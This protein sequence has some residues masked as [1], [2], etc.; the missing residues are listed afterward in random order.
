MAW[1]R[2]CFWACGI[3]VSRRMFAIS[4][5]RHESSSECAAAPL[6]SGEETTCKPAG[7]SGMSVNPS[8]SLPVVVLA[9][10][11][12]LATFSAVLIPTSSFGDDTKRSP[13]TVPSSLSASGIN[14][15]SITTLVSGERF[16]FS[17]NHFSIAHRSYTFPSPARTGCWMTSK[18]NG[19]SPQS[20]C[21]RLPGVRFLI[22]DGFS[23]ALPCLIFTSSPHTDCKMAASCAAVGETNLPRSRPD[24]LPP[25]GF[26]RQS[27]IPFGL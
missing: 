18:V 6:T 13:L 12:L 27:R 20:F 5:F 19:H 25:S 22:S 15:G 14:F 4:R 11:R 21:R 10:G 2:A 17:F 3:D 23:S 8:S 24:V 16:P 9:S 1:M 26:V 7:G